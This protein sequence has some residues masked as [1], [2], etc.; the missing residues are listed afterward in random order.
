MIE[1]RKW[2]SFFGVIIT[3]I[4]KTESAKDNVMFITVHH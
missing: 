3:V 4:H 1:T 2:R